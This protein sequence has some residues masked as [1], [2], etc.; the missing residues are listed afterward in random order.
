MSVSPAGDGNRKEL[1][2]QTLSED[3]RSLSDTQLS[4]VNN[5]GTK[6]SLQWPGVLFNCSDLA[7]LQ[8][9]MSWMQLPAN[10]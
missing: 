6:V 3:D 5:S 8:G 1:Q 9:I 10:R 7:A 4:F 2:R